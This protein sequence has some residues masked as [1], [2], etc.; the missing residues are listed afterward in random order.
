MREKVVDKNSDSGFWSAPELDVKKHEEH[1]RRQRAT[2]NLAKV[3]QRGDSSLG[4]LAIQPQIS[5]AS[6]H[7]PKFI[8]AVDF[9]VSETAVAC[10]MVNQ[11]EVKEG[12]L[13]NWSLTASLASQKTVHIP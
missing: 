10:A 11:K 7:P 13:T 3:A 5:D 2:H 6:Q 12:I 8:V 4:S 1:L 9:G